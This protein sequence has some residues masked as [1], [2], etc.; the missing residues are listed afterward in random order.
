MGIFDVFKK[1]TVEEMQAKKN[2]LG[3]LKAL[4]DSESLARAKA[5]EALGALKNTKS[6]E[7]LIKAL[8]DPTKEVRKAAENALTSFKDPLLE[9]VSQ[10]RP[11]YYYII[12]VTSFERGSLSSAEAAVHLAETILDVVQSSAKYYLDT[13]QIFS[14][15]SIFSSSSASVVIG[16]LERELPIEKCVKH[17]IEF[18]QYGSVKIAKGHIGGEGLTTG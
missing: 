7:G 4:Q 16:R 1:A 17:A 13:K 8:D 5:A 9:Y 14:S 2:I 11:G 18:C 3:L 12:S 10:L 15:P 6:I